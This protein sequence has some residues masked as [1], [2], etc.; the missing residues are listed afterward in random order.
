MAFGL[1]VG[2]CTLVGSS[3]EAAGQQ[4]PAGPEAA[5]PT[6]AGRGWL[7]VDLEPVAPGGRGV[8]IR[9]V[10]RGSPARAAGF[11]GGDVI[12]GLGDVTVSSPDELIRAVSTFP[13]GA[14]VRVRALRGGH[15]VTVDVTL[16]RFPGSV[17]MLRMD[18]VGASAPGFGDSVVA[19]QGQAPMDIYT[20]RGKVV[21]IDFWMTACPACRFTGPRLSALD[22]RLGARGLVVIGITDD[23]VRE[24][25]R[26]AA[27]YGMQF[28]I[29]TDESFTTQRAYGVTAFPT[30]FV[31]DRR[32]VVRDVMVGFDPRREREIE[33][34][35]EKLLAEAAP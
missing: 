13:P 35:I 30:T 12:I 15:D 19:V 20:L 1:A 18:K 34:L 26:T 23:P 10:M 17:E 31:V 29:G 11:W 28:A 27:S 33:A 21:V 24:A 14:V 16:G 4:A 8:M 25:A 6:Q 7:G 5:G 22:A 3:R 2:S 32:G 9:H